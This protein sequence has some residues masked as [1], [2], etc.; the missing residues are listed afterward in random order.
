[1]RL[2]PGARKVTL[3]AHVVCSVGWLGAVA[4][5][6]ALAAAVVVSSNVETIRG[7]YFAMELT[8]T[9]VIVPLALG[10]FVTGLV[11]SLGSR[12]GLL[13]HYWV[14]FK[15]VINIVATVLLVTYLRTLA[16]LADTAASKTAFATGPNE[17]SPLLHAIAALV[18]LL[19]AT[20]LAVYK[21]RGVTPFG[22]RGG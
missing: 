17:F 13:R 22:R 2:S 1:M 20:V 12:W 7:A 6:A 11:Q 21:P 8:A 9:F 14:V 19:V 16:E 10:S 3:T 4:A 15:L 18:L 5:F